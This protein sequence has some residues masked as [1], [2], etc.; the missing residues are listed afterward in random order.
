MACPCGFAVTLMDASS[1]HSV[2]V[3]DMWPVLV[4]GA[5]ALLGT[6]LGSRWQA[7]HSAQVQR[8]SLLH[9]Q[10]IT[11]YVDLLA[12][13]RDRRRWLE[14]LTKEY[15]TV[16]GQRKD[17][18]YQPAVPVEVRVDLLAPPRT[19]AAWEEMT[20]AFAVLALE[21]QEQGYPQHEWDLVLPEQKEWAAAVKAVAALNAAIRADLVDPSDRGGERRW[22][23]L[24]WRLT[25]GRR[26]SEQDV[27]G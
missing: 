9:E 5:V 6:Y 26:R 1:W 23:T 25:A 21:L 20:D 22:W 16:R 13:C 17:A 10:R 15:S 2:Q 4:G 19:S 12:D 27:I 3:N 7:R 8:A 18:Q 11:L 14:D 24:A